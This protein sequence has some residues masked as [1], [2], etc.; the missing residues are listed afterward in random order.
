MLHF[1]AI[2]PFT[3]DLLKSLMTEEYLQQFV[4][5]GGT[6]LALHVGHRKSADL[7]LFFDQKVTGVKVKNK[8]VREIQKL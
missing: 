3:L 2:E 8:I 5:V 4:L 7:A 1:N 6:A